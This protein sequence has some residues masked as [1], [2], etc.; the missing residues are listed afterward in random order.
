[1]KA[2]RIP[3]PRRH[4]IALAA[5]W[6]ASIPLAAPVAAANVTW[7]GGAPIF[8]YPGGE[9]ADAA[10]CAGLNN[11]GTHCSTLSFWGYAGNWSNGLPSAGDDV[12]INSASQ[13]YIQV[14]SSPFSGVTALMPSAAFA[15][16]TQ[17]GGGSL[18]IDTGNTL[19]TVA[20]SIDKLSL[21]GQIAIDGSGVINEINNPIGG[22]APGVAVVRGTGATTLHAF[23]D[24]GLNNYLSV[25]DSQRLSFDGSVSRVAS[26]FAL[27]DDA[28]L[29]TTGTLSSG[30]TVY[31]D[32]SS[33]GGSD[34]SALRRYENLGTLNLST[35]AT[36][37]LIRI[38]TLFYN[39]GT[40]DIGSAGH[41]ESLGGGEHGG[42]AVFR[43]GASS[44]MSFAGYHTF[45]AGSTIDSDGAVDF[46]G[47]TAGSNNPNAT[48]NR[49]SGSYRAGS[50]S[51]TGDTVFDTAVQPGS[52]SISG[53]HASFN[54]LS[55]QQLGGVTLSNGGAL[56]GTAAVDV[57]GPLL[58]HGSSGIATVGGVHAFGGLT[59]DGDGTKS[60]G[61]GGSTASAVEN[62]GLALFQGG[63]I[64]L[65]P[66][67]SFVN[68]KGAT[69]DVQGDFGIGAQA[70]APGQA[71]VLFD[72]AGSFIKSAGSGVAS[73]S[74]PFN[75][76]GR[77]EVKS[78]TLRLLGG[79]THSGTFITPDGSADSL[80]FGGTHIFTIDTT[81][82]SGVGLYGAAG[83]VV[84][85]GVTLTNKSQTLSQR[86]GTI[87]AS[88][89][90]NNGNFMNQGSVSS[91][92]SITNAGTFSNAV[93]V[94]ANAIVNSGTLSNT[95]L[96]N[97]GT[98][99]NSGHFSAAA[100]ATTNLPT[101]NNSGSFSNG[102]ALTVNSLGNAA[103]ASLQNSGDM[104]LGG[105][106]DS[107]N[108]GSIANTGRLTLTGGST[109]YA[110]QLRNDSQLVNNGGTLWLHAGDAIS[111]SGSFVQNSGLTRVDG[112]LSQAGGTVLWGG[113]LAGLGTISGG[114]LM[115]NTGQITP[116]NS[117]GTL[118]IND[119][120]AIYGPD[121][122]SGAPVPSLVLEI[123]DAQT[124]DRLVVNGTASFGVSNRVPVQVQWLSASMPDLDDRF[125]WL[126]ASG[127]ISGADRLD[128]S[129]VGLGAPWSAS[130]VAAANTGLSLALSNSLA[131]QIQPVAGA[132]AIASTDYAYNLS[133]NFV[134]SGPISNAGAFYNRSGGYVL[135]TGAATIDNAAGAFMQNRGAL[136]N[137]GSISN[138][139]SFVNHTEGTLNS[140]AGG[141]MVNL[142]SASM[143]NNGRWWNAGGATLLNQGQFA[144]NGTLQNDGTIVNDGG[145]FHVATGGVVNGFGTYRHGN[146]TTSVDGQLQVGFVSLAGGMLS[147]SGT[148]SGSLPGFGVQLM[149]T[150]VAPGDAGI[151]RLTIASDV[152]VSGGDPSTWQIEL[153]AGGQSDQVAI[154]GQASLQGDV[155]YQLVGGYLPHAGDSFTWLTAA[156]GGFSFWGVSLWTVAADGSSSLLA[157]PNWQPV[158]AGDARGYLSF[159]IGGQTEYAIWNLDGSSVTLTFADTLAQPVPEPQSW[160]LM[161]AGLLAT[162]AASRRI[163]RRSAG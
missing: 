76:S 15:S 13:V 108:Q 4:L 74:T 32:G 87:N 135:N 75:N 96:L 141:S 64:E 146:G 8:A 119:Y 63:F 25:A 5:A 31:D 16:V 156:S 161:A 93:Y 68:A 67:T 160:A 18:Y 6:A 86:D 84:N 3:A 134:N 124:H 23:T 123:V 142:A 19:H 34:F 52:L 28:V 2:A 120:L 17:G 48:A 163:R 7:T 37:S 80:Q 41:L 104:V 1:M 36:S 24:T 145:S 45:A 117:P 129:L 27:Y 66:G 9:V 40:V 109:F 91:L 54:S 149:G 98:F 73:I 159:D 155:A 133:N 57:Q 20:A 97:A 51:I 10:D 152:T 147:G 77:V 139:G 26:Y 128:L 89:L 58:A 78:G 22:N 111:G 62:R 162:G 115:P 50:T 49:V 90:V 12:S 130:L 85:T 154:T 113:T 125:D 136:D 70:V 107:Q 38:E 137:Q 151:G 21:A 105:G 148:L 122:T 29:R 126:S 103:G 71:P 153:G 65:A 99:S 47:A 55:G 82:G 101:L 110:G 150:T 60:L 14:W 94:Q 83:L 46:G 72:N 35:A 43:G 33:S 42:T 44:T 158:A 81:L 157:G 11:S 143:V 39:Q 138:A 114:V 30:L 127:G 106:G 118:T 79:G 131:Y 59:F 56:W 53:A 88:T 144:N 140:Y 132:V 100:G 121:A 102:G 116:G 95:A 92:A 61:V 69:F 112:S